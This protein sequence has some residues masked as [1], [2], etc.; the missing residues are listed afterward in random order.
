MRGIAVLGALV[1]FASGDLRRTFQ[2][3]RKRAVLLWKN[4]RYDEAL[5]YFGKALEADP[6]DAKSIRG[7][8]RCHIGKGGLRDA[9]EWAERAIEHDDT[10]LAHVLRAEIALLAA[11]V[12]GT[13]REAA[14]ELSEGDRRRLQTAALASRDQTSLTTPQSVLPKND[15]CEPRWAS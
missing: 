5:V 4:G 8:A 13:P 6:A 11:G 10:P 2:A 1:W 12:W 14:A 3:P 15:R 7:M 9:A